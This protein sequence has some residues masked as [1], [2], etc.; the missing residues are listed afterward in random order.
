MIEWQQHPGRDKQNTEYAIVN[1]RKAEINKGEDGGVFVKR[2]E[3]MIPANPK[4]TPWW[5]RATGLL[6]F[7]D[8]QAAQEY[9]EQW[10]TEGQ[11]G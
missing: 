6:R 8:H 7:T 3:K 4:G 9:A 1:E 2:Y 11:E 5:R 10:L